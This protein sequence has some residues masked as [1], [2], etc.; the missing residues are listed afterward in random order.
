MQLTMQLVD[1]KR[2]G[3]RCLCP[4]FCRSGGARQFDG[5]LRTLPQLTSNAS[6]PDVHRR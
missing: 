4:V 1:A 3:S 6:L 5:I 2:S